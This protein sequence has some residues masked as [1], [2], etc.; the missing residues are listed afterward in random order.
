MLAAARYIYHTDIVRFYITPLVAG[1]LG[2]LAIALRQGG[3]INFWEVSYGIILDKVVGVS[4][5]VCCPS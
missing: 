1:D 5:T 3:N 4:D 2:R